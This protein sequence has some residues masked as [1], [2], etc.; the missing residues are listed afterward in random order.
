MALKRS[1]YLPLSA[2]LAATIGLSACGGASTASP[3]RTGTSSVQKRL[4]ALS[5][6]QSDLPVGWT[7]KPNH[8]TPSIR[9][10]QLRESA[11]TASCMG[12]VNPWTD[13]G[14]PALQ[15]PNYADP[16]GTLIATSVLYQL[17][18][19]ADVAPFL[20]PYANPSYPRCKGISWHQAVLPEFQNYFA[21]RLPGV[22]LGAITVT[23]EPGPPLTGPIDS[24]YVVQGTY[25]I[26]APALPVPVH[27]TQDDVVLTSGRTV[28]EV[29]LVALGGPIPTSLE[30][31]LARVLYARMS[32][33]RS[34][35]T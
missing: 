27:V 8:L 21:N 12:I 22:T 11:R 32:G 28:Q 13:K 24:S 9:A 19:T 14:V 31:S 5:L 30:D 4:A 3:H 25:E 17:P 10:A 6:R 1:G 16:Q 34:V 33:S 18:S 29:D 26:T 15:S 2:L 35:T 23:V 7:S 20:T